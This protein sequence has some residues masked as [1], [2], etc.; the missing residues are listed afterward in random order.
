MEIYLKT[1]A[2]MTPELRN[3]PLGGSYINLSCLL[4]PHQHQF[5][6]LNNEDNKI[7]SLMHYL[8]LI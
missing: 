8:T 7:C 6:A 2:A 5:N 1:N 3:V 4:M